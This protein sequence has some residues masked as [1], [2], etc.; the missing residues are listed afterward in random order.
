MVIKV[1]LF[2]IWLT[3]LID[4]F[5]ETGLF[6]YPLKTWFSNV[7]IW[8]RD[9]TV[10]CNELSLSWRRPLSYRKESPLICGANQWT[11]FSMISASV[12]KELMMIIMIRVFYFC[13][14]AIFAIF[15]ISQILKN[16]YDQ[17]LLMQYLILQTSKKKIF[18]VIICWNGC[19]INSKSRVFWWITRLKD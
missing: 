10:A 9:R 17:L 6:L 14:S 5:H 13:S 18:N 3:T 8:S 7:L 2:L 19:I 1:N 11:G 12:M 4:A 15:L 16:L